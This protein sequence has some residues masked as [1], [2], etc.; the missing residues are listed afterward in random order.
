MSILMLVTDQSP[1]NN[2]FSK[3]FLLCSLYVLAIYLFILYIYLG[4]HI[5][6]GYYIFSICSRDL[7]KLY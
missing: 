2:K 3:S 5:M 7:S 1:C 4:L 6:N